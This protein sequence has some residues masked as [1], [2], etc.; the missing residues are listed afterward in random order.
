MWGA[1]CAAHTRHKRVNACARVHARGRARVH[2]RGRARVCA[3]MRGPALGCWRRGGGG[4]AKQPLETRRRNR[5]CTEQKR[6]SNNA[7]ESPCNDWHARY[8]E[9]V[10]RIAHTRVYRDYWCN[11]AFG[12]FQIGSLLWCLA[13]ARVLA[14][15]SGLFSVFGNRSGERRTQKIRV[16]QN[17]DAECVKTR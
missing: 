1:V 7:T 10:D 9:I 4:S 11:F 8:R 13:Y 3:R 15:H 12:P 17:N 14:S 6:Q 2:A 16:A 5:E